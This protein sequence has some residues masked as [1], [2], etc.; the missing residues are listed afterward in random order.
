[1][2]EAL[3]NAKRGDRWQAFSAGS[4]PADAVNPNA[5]AVLAE[6]G[7]QHQG[8]PQHI[9]AYLGQSFD[10]VLTVCDHA[11]EVCPVWPG[12]GRREH[13]GFPDPANATGTPEA[14]L[15]VYR[16]VRDD[17]DQQVLAL[18]DTIG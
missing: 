16:Q 15:N 18:L 8:T 5:L 4:Q 13:I 10:L 17:I 9:N 2:A 11:A 7:I 3:I 1:M 12:Q 14:V 6:I